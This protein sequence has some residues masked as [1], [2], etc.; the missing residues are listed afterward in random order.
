MSRKPRFPARALLVLL[1]ITTSIKLAIVL[2]PRSDLYFTNA[3]RQPTTFIGEEVHRGTTALDL[4]EG[5]VMPVQDYQ[6]APFFGGSLVV[7]YAAIPFFLVFGP[8]MGTLKLTG[9][10][11][12]AVA[13]AFL[14]LALH[15]FAGRRAAWIGGLLFAVAAPGYSIL[16]LTAF[17]THV[18]NN[19]F[20]MICVY[21]F[22]LTSERDRPR[23]GAAFLLGLVAGFATYFGYVILVT[24]GTLLVCALAVERRALFRRDRVIV[25]AG[26]AVGLIPWLVYNATH[27]FAGIE[28]YG[29]PV[30]GHYLD[31]A[32]DVA[33]RAKALLTDAFPRSFFFRDLGS[34]TGYWQGVVAGSIVLLLAILGGLFGRRRSQAAG[35]PGRETPPIT[36]AR[37]ALVYVLVFVAAYALSDFSS[38]GLVGFAVTYRYVYP[39][40]PFLFMAAAVALDA[41]WGKGVSGRTTALGCTG[42][43][44]VLGVTGDA[45]LVE[46]GNYGVNFERPGYSRS[47]LGRFV[48]LTYAESPEH[49]TDRIQVVIDRARKVRSEEEYDLFLFGMG[50]T[51]RHSVGPLE[52]PRPRFVRMIADLEELRLYLLEHIE[53]EY[54]PYFRK[55]QPGEREY[56][57]DQRD[58]FRRAPERRRAQEPH[59]G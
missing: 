12:N 36:P 20:A 10:C 7:A 44:L 16:S 41:L 1:L 25:L 43:L 13:V 57:F 23:P 38:G 33:R 48:V 56:A 42:F 19:A 50:M 47:A 6:Y 26:Y 11:F 28:I 30:G 46:P 22:L 52:D 40:Y 34:W 17:G 59:G 39:L 51:L 27:D 9:I 58:A 37:L 54:K 15:R 21:L 2:A 32:A 4:I 29:A 49:L 3:N 14:F 55:L 5:T 35:G 53:E 24:L 31:S 8:S 18:E 45:G